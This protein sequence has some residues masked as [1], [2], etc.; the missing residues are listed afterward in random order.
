MLNTPKTW[1]AQQCPIMVL[2]H[3]DNPSTTDSNALPHLRHYPYKSLLGDGR[4]FDYGPLTSTRSSPHSR[5]LCQTRANTSLIWAR[6]DAATSCQIICDGAIPIL[7]TSATGTAQESGLLW[8]VSLRYF[9]CS[10]VLANVGLLTLITG[11][12]I[13]VKVKRVVMIMEKTITVVLFVSL[14]T[15]SKGA[16]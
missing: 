3:G 15:Q 10:S 14:D 8:V 13:A 16:Q 5:P 2:Q 7:V 9:S 11:L 4:A 12:A 6:H 1:C